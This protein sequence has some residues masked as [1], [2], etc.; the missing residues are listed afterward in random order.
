MPTVITH[1]VVGAVLAEVIRPRAGRAAALEPP[2]APRNGA[3]WVYVV[4][5]SALCAV[6]PDADV[7]A[8][9]L[10]IPYGAPL[11]HRG[12][13][14]SLPFAAVLGAV[15]LALGF[16]GAVWGGQR[17]RIGLCV[18]L[19]TASHGLLDTFT[20]GGLGVA[21]LAPFDLERYFAPWRPVR[22]SP[23]GLRAFLTRGLPVLASE[24]VWI[25]TPAA[26]LLLATLAR[27]AVGRRS[28]V[29]DV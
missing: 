3:P 25:W 26:V 10:G 18:A 22:V 12:L 29:Q 9:Q 17:L 8:F 2:G 16:R 7:L 24:L 23:I 4:A 13:S 27:R 19:A 11:G 15:V 20:N 14:H 5:A 21:V 1:A 6:L 28:A